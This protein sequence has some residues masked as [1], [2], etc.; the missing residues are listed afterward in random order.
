MTEENLEI[1]I[2]NGYCCSAKKAVELSKLLSLGNICT[3]KKE[4]ELLVLNNALKALKQYEYNLGASEFSILYEN[5]DYDKLIGAISQ[6]SI[7]YAVSVNGI[8]YSQ[9]GDNSTPEVDLILSLL[10]NS[11]KYIEF[12]PIQQ[13]I[14]FLFKF[15]MTCDVTQV[16][17]GDIT[18]PLIEYDV[19]KTGNCQLTNCL[20]DDALNKLTH[21]VMNICDICDCQLKQ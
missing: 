15:K 8:T 21:T 2:T 11:G 17:F 20:S 1:I 19:Y 9:F 6:P 10:S 16:F 13:G 14:D 7:E 4:F 18:N 3:D 5:I 12:I